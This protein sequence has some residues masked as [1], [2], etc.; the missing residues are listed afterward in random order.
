VNWGTMDIYSPMDVVNQRV[1][2]YPLDPPK[3]GAPMID[4]QVADNGWSFTALYIPWQAK[5]ILPSTDSRWL[6]RQ[7]LLNLQDNE[8]KLLLPTNPQ[9]NYGDA[10]QLNDALENNFGFNLSKHW[11]SL[12]VHLIYFNGTTSEPTFN[13][14]TATPA[15]T[16]S[17]TPPVLQ[18]NGTIT[19]LPV[20]YRTETTGFGFSTTAGPVI[21]RGETAYT[22]AISS[23]ANDYFS[24]WS[25]Q[26]ALGVEKNFDFSS[27]TLTVVL[28]YYNG[29]YPNPAD[30][31]I[32]S[33]VRLF[34]NTP[35][36]GFHWSLSDDKTIYG[37]VMYEIPQ[38]GAIAVLGYQMKLTDSIHW[39]ISYR[40]LTANKPGLIQTYNDN[41]HADMK[42]IYYF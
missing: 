22:N 14:T 31:L 15:Q 26:N 36:L 6:P 12:D 9:Y 35:A 34:D 40:E 18:L 1:Y 10:T 13:W 29:K 21:I 17:L 38:D 2:F 25:W 39:D 3:R 23:G 33:R 42:L 37:M 5:A 28:Q 32:S 11:D 8:G 7:T 30:N 24:A 41:N 20:Y 4:F 16:V 27:T 19:L